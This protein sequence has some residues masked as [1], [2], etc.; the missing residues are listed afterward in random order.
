MSREIRIATRKSALALWQAEYVK[1]R[2]EASHPGLKVSLVPMVSRGDKLLDAPLA[3]IGGKGLFVKEL[4]TALM[5]NEADIAVHSMKDVPMEFPEGLGLYC[6]CEREDP[7]DAFVS[8]HFDD[9]DALPPGSVVGTSSLRRQAQLLARRPDLKIQFLRGNVNT[10]L[11]KLDAGEYDAII[12]AAAGLIRL[13]FGE[14]IRSSISVDE[15]LPAG[16]QGA[17]GIECRTTDSEL[18]ALLEC[19]NHAPTATRVVAE[20]ALNKRLN[21]GCQVPIA[22]YAVLEGDQLWLRGLV[23]QPDGTVLLRAEG[24][25]PAAD[26]EALGVQVAEALLDQGAE[27]ILQAVYGEAGHA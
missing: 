10:R 21:G 16:G 1:A 22:C 4:E 25:A 7:R 27:Q 3:K 12:L 24:R 15:S 18:H 14:R 20:R 11:A 8:N 19:L 13:G 5:E 23:G 2:L 26:A 9:L 6:I 17:V